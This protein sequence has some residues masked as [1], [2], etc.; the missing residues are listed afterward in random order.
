[1]LLLAVSLAVAAS[2]AGTA[3]AIAYLA[4]MFFLASLDH[5]GPPRREARPSR[6]R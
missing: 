1:M 3:G 5:R 2:D 6:A 4:V